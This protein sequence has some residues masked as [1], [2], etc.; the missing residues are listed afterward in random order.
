MLPDWVWWNTQRGRRP[1]S[2]TQLRKNSKEKKHFYEEKN[3]YHIILCS[4][5]AEYNWCPKWL[6]YAMWN[7]KPCK[8]P[9]LWCPGWFR[10]CPTCFGVLS[11]SP[12]GH[13]WSQSLKGGEEQEKS[14]SFRGFLGF[15]RSAQVWLPWESKLLAWRPSRIKL[16]DLLLLWDRSRDCYGIEVEIETGLSSCCLAMKATVHFRITN[17]ASR[18]KIRYVCVNR[19]P[20][21]ISLWELKDQTDRSLQETHVE[22]VDD[23]KRIEDSRE[24]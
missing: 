19:M 3:I 8:L 1:E 12:L 18:A 2:L 16:G 21:I 4:Y 14:A 9:L 24:F 15:Y 23:C 13:L 6:P 7:K 20:I 10:G 22:E 5:N 17:S 11:L